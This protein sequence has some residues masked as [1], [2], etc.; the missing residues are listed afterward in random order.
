MEDGGEVGDA[1]RIVELHLLIPDAERRHVLVEAEGSRFRLPTAE[2]P[3]EEDWTRVGVARRHLLEAYG[4]DVPI[5][6]THL[7]TDDDGPE[8]RVPALVVCDPPPRGWNRPDGLS[9]LDLDGEP[10][11]ADDALRPR[12]RSWLAEW[13]T[14]SPVPALRPPWSRPGWFARA[15]A[16]MK[17]ELAAVGRPTQGSVEPV[18]L[19][20]FS[21]ILRT[22]TSGGR[23]FLKAV[24]AFFP[25]EPALTRLLAQAFP[26]DL[27]TVL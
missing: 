4:L 5:L 21:G 24:P 11:D 19:W 18:Q 3:A 13:R 10:P 12:L 16:W 8:P 22:D 6:E 2:R 26:N 20:A 17:T 27:P 7:P 9:W 1:N 15:S 25:H 14:D 23:V